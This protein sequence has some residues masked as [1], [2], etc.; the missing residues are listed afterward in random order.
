MLHYKVGWQ[1]ILTLAH[2]GQ[3][4][5]SFALLHAAQRNFEV[6]EAFLRLC[7]YKAKQYADHLQARK[8]Q[9]NRDIMIHAIPGTIPLAK[10]C[11]LTELVKSS[12]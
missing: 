10:P 7:E 5:G 6:Q 8:R 1:N 12:E 9:K 2:W 4:E 3:A 11:S